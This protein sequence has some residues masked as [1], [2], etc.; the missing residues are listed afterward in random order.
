MCDPRLAVA[1]ADKM[2][3]KK[4]KESFSKKKKAP[5]KLAVKKPLNRKLSANGQSRQSTRLTPNGDLQPRD[6]QV[7]TRL[8][9][10]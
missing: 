8:I 10:A 7:V 5:K 6:P 3:A 4:F 9:G 1:Y 2:F